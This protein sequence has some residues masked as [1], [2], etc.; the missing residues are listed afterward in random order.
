MAAMAVSSAVS[1]GPDV[2]RNVDLELRGALFHPD[3]DTPRDVALYLFER[4]GEWR[5]R[6]MG[7][8][9][10]RTPGGEND[11]R[12]R[13]FNQ[14]DHEGRL[15]EVREEDGRIFMRVEM[16][17]HPD[18]WMPGGDAVYELD[19]R[20]DG[21]RY[22]GT[23]TGVFREVEVSGE[24]RG[25]RR[26][27]PWPDAFA[28]RTPF[29]PGEHPRIL[30]RAEDL[31][32]IR[33]R[34]ETPEG[35]EIVER[36]RLLLGGGEEMPTRFQ[37]ATQSYGAS[38]RLP[39]GAY[40]L[41]HGVGFGMLY[42]LTEDEK[43][44]DLA[45]QSVQKAL[46]GQ[47]DRDPRYS[48]IRPGGKL[49]A[50]SSFAAVAMAYDLCYHAWDEEFRTEVARRIQDAVFAPPGT[51]FGGET[52]LAEPVDGDLVF[53]T[54]G[55]QHSPHSN[56]YGAW[57]GGGGT[58][59][60]AILGDPGTDDE[61][62]ERAHRVF[63]QRARRALEVGYG[64]SAWFFEGHHG[65]RLNS[66]TG[67][68]TY[69]H[70]LRTSLALD[71]V[72]PFSGG[73]WLVSKWMY[74]IVRD[75]NRLRSPMQGIYAS[76]VFDRGGMSTGGDFARGFGIVPEAHRPA[77]LWFYQNEVEPEGPR[78]YDA[79]WYP[80]HAVF[81]LLF[82]PIGEEPVNPGDVISHTL[83]G[84]GE[85]YFV[86]RSG[87]TDG[88]DLVAT[89][90]K[91]PGQLIGHGFTDLFQGPVGDVREYREAEEGRVS[92]AFTDREVFIADLSGLSGAPML[93]LRGP[94][95][96][97]SPPPPPAKEVEGVP[98]ALLERFGGGGG[99]TPARAPAPRPETRRDLRTGDFVGSGGENANRVSRQARLGAQNLEIVTIQP[100]F[101]PNFS[102]ERDDRG[103]FVR[104]GK[105][106]IR[107][108][109][110]E[111]R[112]ERED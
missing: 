93:F 46:D 1:A 80:H 91:N 37:S 77:L 7:W 107:M 98:S 62:T 65:G 90:R 16:E 10:M 92:I 22:T 49:R 108:V 94:G 14:M 9:G 26:E 31:P 56:H 51:E 25:R 45:R 11:N 50:G 5:E 15:Q 81:A 109:D 60:L 34:A 106:I 104:I 69:L 101:A 102:M 38:D 53:N 32:A 100:G 66:N 44:A 12:D 73:E 42:Q 64:D 30:F 85:Q 96:G 71:F 19:L 76:E 24:V 6:F 27:R 43:Y 79:I 28:G 3:P 55:G 61:I 23:F 20:R 72:E 39:V 75:G 52:A 112:L 4:D 2:F 89:S 29:E 83:Y 88:K 95:L 110:G 21:D 18:P 35:R 63:L 111:L 17:I 13:W 105:R 36:L 59:I 87:W 70:A 54:L 82:W 57:N 68:I 40:T 74:E 86:Y 47:R 103:E 97:K 58:A 99:S 41:W 48:F 84:P 67:L 33:A 8:T 78:T